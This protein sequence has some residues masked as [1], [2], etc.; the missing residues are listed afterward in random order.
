[1][2]LLACAPAYATE[3]SIDAYAGEAAVLGKPN[4]RV[5][6]LQPRGSGEG[7]GTTSSHESSGRGT[8]SGGTSSGSTTGRGPSSGGGSP[9]GASGGKSGTSSKDGGEPAGGTSTGNRAPLGTS[10]VGLTPSSYPAEPAGG[11]SLSALDI[12]LVIA[13][14]C[15]LVATA[16]L[17]RRASPTTR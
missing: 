6:H 1:M 16:L 10:R 9:T 8:T 13:G 3:S 15:L 12:V 17:L 5:R 4:H 14:I 11:A 2:C 7:G